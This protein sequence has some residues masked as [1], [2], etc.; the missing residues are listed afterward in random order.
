[1]CQFL[2][3]TVG[4]CT[5]DLAPRER[6]VLE[7]MEKIR[8]YLC[9]NYSAKL[10]QLLLLKEAKI[11]KQIFQLLHALFESPSLHTQYLIALLTGA[12]LEEAL[13]SLAKFGDQELKDDCLHLACVLDRTSRG[14]YGAD[15]AEKA[16]LEWHRR[17][18]ERPI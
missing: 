9:E 8:I 16:E 13:T 2:K 18:T 6:R 10:L 4:T 5:I 14:K 3:L 17:E 11:K 1:M 15:F 7:A 12:G